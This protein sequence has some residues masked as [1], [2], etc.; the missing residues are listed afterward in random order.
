MV[1]IKNDRPESSTPANF[2]VRVNELILGLA[3]K[4]FPQNT[5]TR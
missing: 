2:P 4:R 1:E 3:R 5:L